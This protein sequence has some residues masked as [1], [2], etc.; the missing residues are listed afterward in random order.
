MLNERELLNFIKNTYNNISDNCYLESANLGTGKNY[1]LK[2]GVKTKFFVKYFDQYSVYENLQDEIHANKILVN[3]DYP[4]PHYVLNRRSEFIT[5]IDESSSIIIQ[6]WVTGITP[7][8]FS[9]TISQSINAIKLLARANILLKECNFKP[10]F[11]DLI[12]N[13]NKRKEETKKLLN[14]FILKKRTNLIIKNI[15]IEK[16]KCLDLLENIDIDIEKF[17]FVNSHGDY[18]CLQLMMGNNKEIKYVVDFSRVSKVPAIW[19]I[20]RFY[21]FADPKCRNCKI[22]SKYLT[23]IINEYEKYI[24]LSIYDKKNA[25]ILYAI[26]ILSSHFGYKQYIEDGDEKNLDF[27]IWRVN[28]AKE[29]LNK[30][31]YIN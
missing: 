6:E 12:N 17:T 11:L 30:C 5:P 3:N 28:F 23:K 18:N 24:R 22:D 31:G 19:E 21:S 7:E 9:L 26:Q 2:C 29:L 13:I 1:L 4:T 10:M 20:I 16:I 15:L 25:Y 27:A 8:K 14:I